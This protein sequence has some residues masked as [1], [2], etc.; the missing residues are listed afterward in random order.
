[1]YKPPGGLHLE[2]CPQIEIKT[3]QKRNILLLTTRLAQSILKCKFPSVDKPL[4]KE[5]PLKRPL[6]NISPRAY[7]RNFTVCGPNIVTFQICDTDNY[8]Y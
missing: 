2:N 1:M 3:K 5:A 8:C 7:F 4:Q 6:K